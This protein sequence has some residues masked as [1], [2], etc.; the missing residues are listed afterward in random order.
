MKTQISKQH[1]NAVPVQSQTA[2][3]KEDRMPKR[4]FTLT[5][6]AVFALLAVL[7][8]TGDGGDLLGQ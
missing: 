6:L 1:T 3:H 2:F 7:M 8:A 4:S 5:R